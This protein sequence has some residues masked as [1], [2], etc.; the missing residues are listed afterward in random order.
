M[1]GIAGYAGPRPLDPERVQLAL[2][3]LRHRGP[4]HAAHRAFTT[5][6]GRHVSLLHARLSIIDLDAR[7]DQPLRAGTRWLA[8]NGELYN[9][10]ELRERLAPPRRGLPD[11][12]RHGGAGAGARRARLGGAGLLRGDVGVRRYDEADGTL[13]LCRDRFGEKPL[14]LHRDGDGGVWFASEPKA[15]FALL[16]R[17]LPPNCATS[18]ASWSTATRACTRPARPSSRA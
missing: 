1:C 2:A 14:Y 18:A 8:Y 11:R 4:D 16:G 13:S 9:Y 12:F 10:L 5:P 15:L 7:S 3:R 6:D 17:A